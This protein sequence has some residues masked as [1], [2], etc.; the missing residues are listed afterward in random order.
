MEH[1]TEPET[2]EN[3]AHILHAPA[4]AAGVRLDAY[5]AANIEGWSRARLQKLISE[6][7]VLVNERP[8]KAS[9]KLSAGDSVELELPPR[10]AAGEFAPE[11]LPLEIVYEDDE[12][13]VVNKA[14]GV[15]VHPASGVMSGTLANGLAWHFQQLSQHG[16]AFRPGIVHRLDKDTSGLLVVAKTDAAHENLAD[17]FRSREVFKQYLAL[18]HGV[19]SE[20]SGRVEQPIGRDPQNRTRMAIVRHGRYALSLWRV[21]QRFQRFTL[22]RVEIKTGRTHQIRV[23]LAS[24]KHP[25]A[26]DTTYNNGRDNTTPDLAARRAIAT[27]GRQFLHAEKIGFRHPRT[28]EYLR[29]DAVLPAELSSCLT[30][31]A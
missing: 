21:R 18:V 15:I 1:Q 6:G 16:G 13:I 8:A 12:I 4:E 20:D 31:L 5:L 27:L 29:F 23:H 24:I 22:V 7:E 19:M 3:A 17:Q 14:A 11:E 10:L 9:Y 30:Q 28:G 25:V 2:T 26:G